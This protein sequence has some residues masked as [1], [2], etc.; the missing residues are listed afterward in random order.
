MECDSECLMRL[1]LE[2]Q[3]VQDKERAK[4][5]GEIIA[6]FRSAGIGESTDFRTQSRAFSALHD[7]VRKWGEA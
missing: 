1:L 3:A 7:Y 6:L 4:E 5:Q 2:R